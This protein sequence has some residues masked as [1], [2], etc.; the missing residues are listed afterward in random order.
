MRVLLPVLLLAACTPTAPAP[1]PASPCAEQRFEQAGFIVCR[2]GRVEMRSGLR[3]FQALQQRL[4]ARSDGVAFAMNG[5]MFDDAGAPIGLLI[6]DVGEVVPIILGEGG[7][8]FHLMT[9]GVFLV[10]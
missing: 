5:G 10:R 7:G 6:E 3:S 8:Y 9:Y 1:A 2:G 4:G